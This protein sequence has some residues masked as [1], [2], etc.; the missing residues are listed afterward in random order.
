M[1]RA[2]DILRN[3]GMIAIVPGG[4][5]GIV[6]FFCSKADKLAGKTRFLSGM[7]P[8]KGRVVEISE[9][10]FSKSGELGAL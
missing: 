3:N 9:N 1:A 8:G 6:G 5:P 7:Y 2:F 4:L 10:F